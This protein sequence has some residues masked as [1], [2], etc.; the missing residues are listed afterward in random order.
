MLA[1]KAVIIKWLLCS[2]FYFLLLASN[3]TVHCTTKGFREALRTPIIPLGWK[4]WAWQVPPFL[5]FSWREV[6]SCTLTLTGNA[7][8]CPWVDETPENWRDEQP[9][10]FLWTSKQKLLYFGVR[11]L[12]QSPLSSASFIQ[13]WT[14]LAASGCITFPMVWKQGH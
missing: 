13:P 14:A 9:L 3:I 8:S 2:S 7:A 6:G 10:P 1:H 12:C 4:A 5:C 11:V